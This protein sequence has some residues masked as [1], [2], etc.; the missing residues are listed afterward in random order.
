M[1]WCKCNSNSNVLVCETQGKVC[2]CRGESVS[3]YW[4]SVCLCVFV[5][6]CVCVLLIGLYGGVQRTSPQVSLYKSHTTEESLNRLGLLVDSEI[7]FSTRYGKTLTVSIC[8]FPNLI[9]Y[10]QHESK[11]DKFCQVLCVLTVWSFGTSQET[12]ECCW[13]RFH[14]IRPSHTQTTHHIC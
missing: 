1:R 11:S 14:H 6:V 5:R 8:Q 9:N 3:E 7:V 4:G 12:L 2:I 10:H 13:C